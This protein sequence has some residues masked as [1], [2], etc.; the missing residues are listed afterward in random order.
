MDTLKLQRRQLKA[1]LTRTEKYL[2]K[3]EN[4]EGVHEIHKRYDGF[5]TL[6]DEFN[7]VQ[8]E[9]ERLDVTEFDSNVREEFE[10]RYYSCDARFMK[11]ISK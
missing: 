10:D 9:I 1:A 6:L 4:N 8:T 11:I 5:V 3:C 7:P 2:N